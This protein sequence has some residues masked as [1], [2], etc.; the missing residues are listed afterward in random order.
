MKLFFEKQIFSA[1]CANKNKLH[2]RVR[3]PPRLRWLRETADVIDT[4]VMSFNII[5]RLWGQLGES[6]KMA[7]AGSLLVH[8]FSHVCRC[9][10]ASSP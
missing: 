1:A 8:M 9:V 7:V 2:H 5:L 3:E 4:D 6:K 10:T